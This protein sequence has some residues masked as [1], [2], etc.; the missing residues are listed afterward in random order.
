MHS[1]LAQDVS[2]IRPANLRLSHFFSSLPLLAGGIVAALLPGLSEFF[3]SLFNVLPTLLLL[4]GGA[5]CLVYGRQREVFLLLALYVGY[6]LLDIQVDHFRDNGQIRGDAALVFHLICQ[7]SYSRPEASFTAP[8]RW[9]ALRM[10]L[11]P[12]A[13]ALYSALSASLITSCGVRCSA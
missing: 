13:L 7:R 11:R 9:P 1:S 10:Q 12:A 8:R 3:I 5:F 2:V 6:F 4:L